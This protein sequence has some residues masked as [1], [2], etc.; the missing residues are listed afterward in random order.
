MN[1]SASWLCFACVFHAAAIFAADLRVDRDRPYA[2]TPHERQVLDV[3][4]SSS[5][6]KCPVIVWIH[7]GGWAAGDKSQMTRKP[8]TF[9]DAGYVF[10][11]PNRRFVPEASLR[12]ITADT[13]KAIRWAHEHAREFGGDPDTIFVMGHSS[14][15]NLAALVSTDA[16]YLEAEGLPLSTIKGCAPLDGGMYD[17][18]AQVAASASDAA[19]T[20]TYHERYGD[21]DGQ[22]DMSPAAHVRKGRN[23]PP[24]LI[25][26]IDHP[27]TKTQ[28][29]EFAK[30]LREA[31]VPV[32]LY[33][34]EDKTHATLNSEIG[35]PDN[36][37]TAAIFRFLERS[38]KRKSD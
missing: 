33:Y 16:R 24:F 21:I 19:R 29:Q 27:F 37:P 15:A 38:T 34:A 11:A 4:S 35:L 32:E 2:D 5:G 25:F 13:A 9:V 1:S 7:G 30:K 20:A 6:E 22:R 14:G 36:K 31:E 26:H 18:P 8:R 10:I 3:Y 12:E 28:S 23:I 17:V